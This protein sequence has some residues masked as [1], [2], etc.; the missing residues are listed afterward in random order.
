MVCY[1]DKEEL[2][3]L[4]IYF[5]KHPEERREIAMKAKKRVLEEHTY[6]HRI[7]KLIRFVRETFGI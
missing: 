7:R 4:S 3:E 5:L 6:F 1:R 2:R